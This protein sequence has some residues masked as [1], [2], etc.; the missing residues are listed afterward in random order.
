M[1]YN[2]IWLIFA[3]HNEEKLNSINSNIYRELLVDG[4][5]EA[6]DTE[7]YTWKKYHPT[8]DKVA[9]CFKIGKVPSWDSVIIRNIEGNDLVSLT[10]DWNEGLEF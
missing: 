2:M 10:D 7:S 5:I 6:N 9:A 4:L 3:L 1:G 8:E